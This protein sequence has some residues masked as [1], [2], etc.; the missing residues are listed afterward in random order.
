MEVQPYPAVVLW[1]RNPLV[2]VGAGNRST[3][4]LEKPRG[5]PRMGVVGLDHL[6]LPR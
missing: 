2:K 1:D 6:P 5:V 3:R 4:P